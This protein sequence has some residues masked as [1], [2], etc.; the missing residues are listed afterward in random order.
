LQP[1]LPGIP[2]LKGPKDQEVSRGYQATQEPQACRVCKVIQVSQATRVSQD[3]KES[4]VLTAVT[5][6][7]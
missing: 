4:L 2:V 1:V 7:R 5:V 6:L 3:F